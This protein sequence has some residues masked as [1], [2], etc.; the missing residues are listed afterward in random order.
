MKNELTTHS[1]RLAQLNRALLL[2]ESERQGKDKDKL[3]D[4]IEKLI[5]KENERHEKAMD[6]FKSG[7]TGPT[8][9]G[10]TATGDTVKT[11]ATPAANPGTDACGGHRHR[12]D[13]AD[14]ADGETG[15]CC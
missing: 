10:P 12:R 15:T 4:R 8:A 9:A 13:A 2:A 14:P 11:G 1:R 5:D 3:V 6:R 7:S